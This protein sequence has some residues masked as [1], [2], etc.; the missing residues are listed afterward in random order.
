MTRVRF[1][2]LLLAALA[3]MIYLLLPPKPR[4]LST[5]ALLNAPVVRGAF[6]VHTRRSD[7]SGTIE[8]VAA[9]AGRARLSF[10]IVTDHGDAARP[11][12]P[13]VYLDGVLVID[14]VE[15]STDGGHVV[16]LGMPVA[17]YPLAGEARDVVEDIARLGGMSIAAHPDS[18][19]PS[20][21]WTDW[22][23][24]VDGI[25]WLNADSEWRDEGAGRLARAIMTYPFRRPETLA[26]LL[27]RQDDA[28]K[29]WEAL[30]AR[31][32][33]VALAAGD[34][35]ARI[36]L[37]GEPD[38]GRFA[39][40]LPAYE[41]MFRTFSIAIP[42][43]AL[44]GDAAADAE[45]I[46]TSV[47]EGNVFSS[48]DAIAAPSVLG[49]TGTSSG[50]R[51]G[52]GGRLPV[53]KPVDFTVETN[54][55]ADARI[56]L[57]KDGTVVTEN[58]GPT[59]RYTAP[60]GPGVYRV[61]VSLPG[62]PGS[63]AIPW[64]FSNPIYVRPPAAGAPAVRPAATQ[65]AA[66]YLDGPSPGWAV[67]TSARAKGTLDGTKTIDGTELTLRY[68]LGG[69][70]ADSPFVAL[71]MPVGPLADY[72]RLTF[73]ARALRPM[74]VSVEL[75]MPDGADGQRWHRSVYLDET[76]RT[77]SVF[78]DEMT[79]RGEVSRRSPDLSAVDTVLFV[80]DTVNAY[81][82][83]NGQFW[84]DDVVYGR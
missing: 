60:E 1:A 68:A 19:K 76:P 42:R 21:R 73:T 12:E 66:L 46:V 15:V 40:H 38:A 78:F 41:E 17:P 70:L 67:E 79:P 33:V 80:V 3:A 48:I 10:V 65:T 69:S 43:L 29:R 61:E 56:R 6:H 45:A 72:D 20:L 54:A 9:A 49:F 28:I 22:S 5:E 37:S 34:A 32:P 83:S 52:I 13:P 71:T 24:P 14:A 50:I 16:A 75:R 31:R 47:L 74:R 77:V 18:P 57:L 82:G 30:L 23:S 35:H 8:Q 58:G 4:H 59:L 63:P 26:T 62:A 36:G 55:P 7:G 53:G 81:P 25:E 39:L 64:I 11:P 27:D 51:V 2:L 44:S 84:L